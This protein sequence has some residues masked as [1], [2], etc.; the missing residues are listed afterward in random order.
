MAAVRGDQFHS[1]SHLVLIYLLITIQFTSSSNRPD[2]RLNFGPRPKLGPKTSIAMQNHAFAATV[3]DMVE[4][5]NSCIDLEDG[6]YYIKPTEEGPVIPAICS[7][8][9]TMIDILLNFEA[10]TQYFSTWDYSKSDT[11]LIMPSLDE[12]I[13]WRDWWTVADESY[14]FRAA[15]NCHRCYEDDEL[16]DNAAYYMSSYYFCF[17]TAMQPECV[18][19]SSATGFEHACAWCDDGSGHNYEEAARQWTKCTSL[20]FD[21]DTLPDADH[22]NCVTHQLIYRP[23]AVTNRDACTCYKESSKKAATSYFVDRSELPTVTLSDHLDSNLYID[24]LIIPQTDDSESTLTRNEPL[25]IVYLNQRDFAEGTYRIVSPG[26]YI[27]SE[28]IVVK[29]N[30]PSEEE[31]QSSDFSANA[32]DRD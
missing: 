10:I 9:Y 14:S 11:F 6:L 19:G 4:I 17:S 27:L 21:A 20:R 18:N 1:T 29:F 24:S 30:A 26:E 16:G 3:D 23:S 31:Q 7:E 13:S 25:S 12:M 5:P 2:P 15:P 32:Y 22:Y 28:D 8:S